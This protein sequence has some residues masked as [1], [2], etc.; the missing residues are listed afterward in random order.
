MAWSLTVAAVIER[1]GRFLFVEE[2]DGARPERVFNQPA[3]HVDPGEDLLAA[4]IRE[5]REE[6]GLEFRPEAFV[7]IYLVRAANGRDYARVCFAGSVPEGIEPAP[8]DPVIL[9]CAWLTREEAALR[10]RSSAVLA[11]LDDYLGGRRLPL[12]CVQNFLD[13]RRPADSPWAPLAAGWEELFPLRQP[14]L[15]L[16]LGLAGPGCRC[17]DAGCATGSLPRA[18]AARGRL[19]HGLVVSVSAPTSHPGLRLWLGCEKQW[20]SLYD[21]LGHQRGGGGGCLYEPGQSQLAA[22]ANEHAHDRLRRF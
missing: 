7:G 8:E 13:D 16:A 9:A 14:R 22:N 18:L 19:A 1:Q 2:T 15:D 3:G 6:T 10:P 4:V 20:L 5:T 21:F 11:C 17:L 12:A